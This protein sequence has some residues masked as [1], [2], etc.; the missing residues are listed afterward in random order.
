MPITQDRVLA[1][2]DAADDYRNAA[3]LLC[4]HIQT[5]VHLAETHRLNAADVVILRGLIKPET[6]IKSM[7]SFLT[8]ETERAHFRIRAGR[9]ARQQ[10]WL[11]RR[12][13]GLTGTAVPQSEPTIE[14]TDEADLEML[15]ALMATPTDGRPRTLSLKHLPT[16]PPRRPAP[17]PY[18]GYNPADDGDPEDFPDP[19]YS[20]PDLAE[21]ATAQNDETED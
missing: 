18:G 2:I 8:I 17:Q 13:A 14:L 21:S 19:T 6:V 7:Q 20:G 16:E 10:R 5:L 1:L 3:Q 9:N 15:A 4:D 12:K 11:A